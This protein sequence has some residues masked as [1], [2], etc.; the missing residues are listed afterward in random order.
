MSTISELVQKILEKKKSKTDVLCPHGVS[1]RCKSKPGPKKSPVVNARK[2]SHKAHLDKL[3]RKVKR[4]IEQLRENR[5]RGFPLSPSPR[6][7]VK[8]VPQVDARRAR[9]LEL[10]KE[11]LASVQRMRKRK[12]PKRK[13]P[14]SSKKL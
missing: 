14:K 9:N 6:R 7:K 13:S 5:A 2:L 3:V 10:A 8:V 11:A 1:V 4:D 12:S